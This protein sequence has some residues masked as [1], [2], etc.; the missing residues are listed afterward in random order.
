VRQRRVGGQ[1]GDAPACDGGTRRGQF[2]V[3]EHPATAQQGGHHSGFFRAQ[4]QAAGGDEAQ[5]ACEFPYH[6]GEAGMRQPFLHRRQHFFSGFGEDQ[7]AGVQTGTGEAGGE[8]IRPLLDPQDRPFH[9]R[10][11]AGEEQSRRGA[12]LGIRAGPRDL[13]QS[14]Q[15]QAA[16][17][18]GV[19]EGVIEGGDA[20]GDYPGG[21]RAAL[22]TMGRDPRDLVAKT[23]KRLG[24]GGR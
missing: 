5:A 7:A 18:V 12:M 13:M 10:Q 15:K 4:L 23:G 16:K 19:G 17:G 24:T 21:G 1:L 22:F 2:G 14:A 9:P 8:Q 3:V 11:H 20:E 6:G